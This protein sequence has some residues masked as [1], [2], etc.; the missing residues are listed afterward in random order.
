MGSAEC[1]FKPSLPADPLYSMDFI[2]VGGYGTAAIS[3]IYGTDFVFHNTVFRK[4]I[5]V[6]RHF[7]NGNRFYS[8]LEPRSA[9]HRIFIGFSGQ[10]MAAAGI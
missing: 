4:A 1:F 9:D 5:S 2:R 7:F 10:G 3:H 8:Q 6:V